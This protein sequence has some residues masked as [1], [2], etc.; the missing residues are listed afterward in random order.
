M[1]A[2]P[3]PEDESEQAKVLRLPMAASFKYDGIR[4]VI[5]DGEPL[6]RALKPIP[7]T[8]IRQTLASMKL[9]NL[10]G[11]LMV[12]GAR[13]FSDISSAVM[14]EHGWP[15]FRFHVFDTFQDPNLPYMQRYR[16]IKR[17]VRRIGEPLV[18]VETWKLENLRELAGEVEYAIDNGYEGIMLRAMDSPY[19]FGRSTLREGYLLK[20]KRFYTDEGVVIG[21]EEGMANTNEQERD[22]RGYAKRSTAK[23]GKVPANT[24]GNFRVRWKG[25]RVVTVSAR[26]GL[27]DADRKKI[28]DN[29]TEYLDRIVRFR[30]QELGSKGLPRF[31][32]FDGFRD[33]RDMGTQ[34]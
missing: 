4:C 29:R 23:A 33:P 1:L 30:Y 13:N 28:W 34:V 27:T 24:L 20:V 5:R 21:F 11:E 8:S 3:I 26:R 18:L 22:E 16:A 14:S 7:N 32:A 10:D 31:P 2:V 19:K 6:T 15:D 12:Q 17:I 25:G 9:P